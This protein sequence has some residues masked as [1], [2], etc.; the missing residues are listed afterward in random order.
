MDY[1]LL[2]PLATH[3]NSDHNQ[4][5]NELQVLKP[6]LGAKQLSSIQELYNEIIPLQQAFPNMTIMIK[7]ALTIPI[8]STTCERT[9]SKM[10]LIKTRIRN[11]MKDERLSDLCLL[12]IERDFQIDFE[13]VIDKFSINHNNSRIM[14]Q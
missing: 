2:L 14:L 9:F 1:A 5:F 6:M 12:S 8:S 13:Q 7:A 10:K 4:V 11:T 3:T